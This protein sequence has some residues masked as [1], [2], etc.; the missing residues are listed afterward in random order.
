MRIYAVDIWQDPPQSWG[1][2]RGVYLGSGLVITAAPC[3]RLGGSN[4]TAGMDLPAHAIKEGNF[5][6]VDRRITGPC[7]IRQ[8]TSVSVSPTL[9][10]VIWAL[11]SLLTAQSAVRVL[12]KSIN[13][14]RPS[15]PHS[16]WQIRAHYFHAAGAPVRYPTLQPER[17]SA[18]FRRAPPPSPPLPSRFRALN[19]RAD[20]PSTGT[21]QA[22]ASISEIPKFS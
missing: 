16:R 2:G 12:Y 9:P 10:G 6:R 7:A 5:V 21:P 8:R 22:I 14:S 1:P 11:K 3:C 17:S 15:P 19:S 4:Q 20:S 18:H 13:L